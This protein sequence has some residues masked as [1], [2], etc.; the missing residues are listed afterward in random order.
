MLWKKKKKVEQGRGDKKE[1]FLVK[2]K[3]EGGEGISHAH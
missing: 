3:P 1:R 2:Q